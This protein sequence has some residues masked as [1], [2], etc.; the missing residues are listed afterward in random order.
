MLSDYRT[1]FR[2]MMGEWNIFVN[3][4]LN[5][6]QKTNKKNESSKQK[7]NTGETFVYKETNDQDNPFVTL[8]Y[9]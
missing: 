9:I 3:R 7:R 8:N 4:G 5:M 6:N 1:I 2:Y